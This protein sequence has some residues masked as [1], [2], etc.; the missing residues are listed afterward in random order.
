MPDPR[1]VLFSSDFKK[2]QVATKR[3][4]M[5]RTEPSIKIELIRQKSDMS[6]TFR[7]VR[8]DI[9]IRGQFML[10]LNMN[11]P[12]Y[13]FSSL[14]KHKKTVH[15]EESHRPPNR[16]I[17]KIEPKPDSMGQFQSQN[18]SQRKISTYQSKISPT[19]VL[20]SLD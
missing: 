5:L 9:L 3:L 20:G 18:Q 10:N 2:L 16:K 12:L 19:T 1:C 13:H 6:V 4:Q 8:R 15:G 7:I 17:R 14:R 11:I